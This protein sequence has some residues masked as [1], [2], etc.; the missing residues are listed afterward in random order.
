MCFWTNVT[1]SLRPDIMQKLILASLAF[2]IAATAST[3][4]SIEVTPA[5]RPSPD[6][7]VTN[8]D[9]LAPSC[10]TN[11]SAESHQNPESAALDLESYRQPAFE[12]IAQPR[13]DGATSGVNFSKSNVG[14][15]QHSGNWAQL[16]TSHY[17]P[18]KITQTIVA[19]RP[20]LTI[21][22]AW[23]AAYP[24]IEYNRKVAVLGGAPPHKYELIAAPP[25]M[26]IDQL[27]GVIL[28]PNPHESRSPH[29]VTVQV[30]DQEATV[31]RVSWEITVDPK[32]FIFVDEIN[33]RN[34]NSGILASPKKNMN[35]W[36]KGEKYDSTYETKHVI[37]RTGIYLVGDLPVQ[38]GQ[39]QVGWNVGMDGNKPRVHY[40]YPGEEVVWDFSGAYFNYGNSDNY[41][42]DN[43]EFRNIGVNNIA[44]FGLRLAGSGSNVT[45]RRIKFSDI[46]RT[47]A[48]NKSYLMASATKK[49]GHYWAVTESVFDMNNAKNTVAF[50][51][52]AASNGVFEYNVLRNIPTSGK[53]LY[54]KE[55]GLKFWSVRYNV[56]VENVNSLLVD[57]NHNSSTKR[58][59]F[60]EV[61]YNKGNVELT[62]LRFSLDRST[63]W[64]TN[65]FPIEIIGS[66]TILFYGQTSAQLTSKKMLCIGM[67]N[68]L[69][70]WPKKVLRLR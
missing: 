24:G 64:V 55:G 59:N 58:I 50:L 18:S 44:T 53:G 34:S 28:W 43:M 11:A 20:S 69:M 27:T 67:E 46:Q 62:K 65:Y 19:P 4:S 56:A 47:A 49:P 1:Y 17:V 48:S 45:I 15:R 22:N 26:S 9:P 12:T 66:D 54:L 39:P 52:Y 3:I 70:R 30:T 29:S 7:R 23:Y 35:G 61:C 13:P 10:G 36:Y 68:R 6:C 25:G 40:S 60:V 16:L 57:M 41:Y 14:I 21:A 33:G 8:V 5:G 42:Y 38:G 51:V 2:L 31:S 37:Y 63:T 32:I